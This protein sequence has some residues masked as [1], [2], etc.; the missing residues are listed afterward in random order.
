MNCWSLILAAVE[1]HGTCALVSV[2]DTKGS[3]PREVGARMIVTP[4][5]FHGT[6]GGGALEWHAMAK[7]QSL[8]ERGAVSKLSSHALGPELGQCCGGRMQLLTESFDHTS[9]ANLRALAE[10]ERGGSFTI[11]NRNP[12]I[13]IT[14]TFGVAQ[15]ELFLFGAGHV[16][17]AI[18]LAL[19]PLPFAIHW[20]DPRPNAFPATTPLN[21]STICPPD[22]IACLAEAK[23]N[24]F[25]V[26]LTHSHALD[27][28]LT[29]ASLR[30]PNIIETGLIGSATKRARFVN[31]LQ[32]MHVDSNQIT[33]LICP[34]GIP[35]ITSKEPAMIAASV[36]AQFLLL[37]QK[38]QTA[39]QSITPF[40]AVKENRA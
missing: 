37:D 13:A 16:G 26:I 2:V 12:A 4:Q 21:V 39:L 33:K 7:A 25:S 38:H 19:A 27:L 23:P 15:R 28:S 31:R 30:N 36:A 35:G 20:I 34:I 5:G 40:S 11:Q 29:D 32:E 1:T 18:V 10:R 17:R 3:T 22:P 9:L 6:I 14:E 24:S 8:L